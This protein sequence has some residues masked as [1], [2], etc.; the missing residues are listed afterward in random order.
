MDK[1]RAWISAF[2]LAMAL[3]GVGPKVV[4]GRDRGLSGSN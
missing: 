1:V 3:A 2:Q 4:R